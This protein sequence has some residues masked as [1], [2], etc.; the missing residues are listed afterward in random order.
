[1]PGGI[2]AAARAQAD[3]RDATEHG[4]RLDQDLARP[5]LEQQRGVDGT[6]A[7]RVLE[8]GRAVEIGAEEIRYVVGRGDLAA[9]AGR[10]RA[11]LWRRDREL[12]CGLAHLASAMLGSTDRAGRPPGA[13]GGRV[14]HG[15]SAGD[16]C[17][18]VIYLF[19][20]GLERRRRRFA[21]AA[22]PHQPG[23]LAVP[24]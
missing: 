7:Q 21:E 10:D 17:S 18:C 16:V 11:V 2:G 8:A 23:E 22:G 12:A 9:D 6:G 13:S 14:G 15:L 4:C 20:P 1:G 24:E 19:A 5:G 3:S